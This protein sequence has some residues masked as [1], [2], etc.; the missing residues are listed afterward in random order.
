MLKLS[1]IASES[2]KDTLERIEQDT[3]FRQMLRPA[4]DKIRCLRNI[5]QT[6]PRL[7]GPGHRC[8]GTLAMP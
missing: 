1:M 5:Y 7:Y 2:V 3:A 6:L 4:L 8:D